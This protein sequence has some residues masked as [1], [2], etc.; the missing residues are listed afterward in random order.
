MLKNR[1]A[2]SAVALSQDRKTQDRLRQ[3]MRTKDQEAREK[4]GHAPEFCW[5]L[6]FIQEAKHLRTPI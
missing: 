5:H 4:H 3:T 2:R 6:G 1:S